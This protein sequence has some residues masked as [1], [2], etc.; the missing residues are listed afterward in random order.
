M[1]GLESLFSLSYAMSI[2]SSKKV[3]GG[4]TPR[5]AETYGKEKTKQKTVQG[6][7]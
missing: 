1:L 7:K 5:T 4:K 2:V 3:K 6:A